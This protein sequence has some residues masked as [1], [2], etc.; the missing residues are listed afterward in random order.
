[1]MVIRKCL[2]TFIIL[3]LI[4]EGFGQEKSE[5]AVKNQFTLEEAVQYAIQNGYDVK[6]KGIDLTVAKKKIWEVTAM[7]L[8]QVS[9]SVAY[10]HVFEVPVLSFGYA[11]DPSSL[12][13]GVNLTKQDIIDAYKPATPISLGVANNTTWDVTVSQ[14]IFSGE[15]IVGL[16][17]SKVFR[18]MSE[19]NLTKSYEDI[20]ES[21]STSYYLA[22]VIDE[23]V[24]ILKETQQ[25]TDSNLKDLVAMGDQG[26][27]EQTGVDQVRII[28]ST[29]DNAVSSLERAAVV[30]KNLLKFQMGLPIE[31]EITLTDKLDKYTDESFFTPYMGE[32]FDVTKTMDYQILETGVKLQ[33]LNWDREK[34]TFL[35][36]LAG[37]FRHYEQLKSASFNFQP[38]NV[39]GI[40]ISV[41]IF[42]SGMRGVKV[43]Q[44]RLN[45]EK[46]KLSQQQATE[47]L[48]LQYQN[49]FNEFQTAF[50]SFITNKKNMELAKRI[51]DQ[52]MIK[53]KEGVSSAM[54]LNTA[55]NQYLTT[56]RDYFSA[57]NSLLTAKVKL[58]KLLSKN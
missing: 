4:Y 29:I 48:N 2:L 33:K 21:V 47:G 23:N 55:E 56:Q 20:K 18:E 12:P 9:G 26:L 52:T 44:A 40:N 11:F 17:A 6:S 36:S 34:T 19:Q 35:P 27:V 5:T 43:Q 3:G 1:M 15:Y 10:Q 13:S 45:F 58:N 50:S 22:L 46:M 38:K 41:P 42:S 32:K 28:K 54:D 31:S 57:L 53:Y 30:S 51:F 8:P 14:L 7:G 37:Y 49:T 25:I 39:A 16:R 24:R